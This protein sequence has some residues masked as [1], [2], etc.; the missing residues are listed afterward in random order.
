MLNGWRVRGRRCLTYKPT[1]MQKREHLLR[2]KKS[3]SNPYPYP[4]IQD[5]N[6]KDSVWYIQSMVKSLIFRRRAVK[7]VASLVLSGLPIFAANQILTSWNLSRLATK[8]QQSEAIM[9]RHHAAQDAMPA[10]TADQIPADEK[11]CTEESS[12]S[13]TTI[14]CSYD[15]TAALNRWVVEEIAGINQEYAPLLRSKRAEIESMSLWSFGQ[16]ADLARDVYVMHVRA[17]VGAMEEVSKC[18]SYQC[19][20]DVYDFRYTEEISRTFA[21]AET[22]I[23]RI[24]PTLDVFKANEKLRKIFPG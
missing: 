9:K 21:I 20:V 4:T 22:E 7:W 14:S 11:F 15:E 10:P 12:G 1:F 17:W 18:K 8:M 16:S 13:T 2:A 5:D 24:S 6:L 23:A 3:N 19:F